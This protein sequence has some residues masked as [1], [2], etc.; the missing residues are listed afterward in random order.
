MIEDMEALVTLLMECFEDDVM[1]TLARDDFSPTERLLLEVPV[2][3]WN[4]C[5]R[6]LNLNLEF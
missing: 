3:L 5:V 1:V 4:E 6:I 2:G